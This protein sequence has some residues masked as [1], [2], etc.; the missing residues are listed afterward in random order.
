MWDAEI[1]I[2][3]RDCIYW[4]NKYGVKP[5]QHR[6]DHEIV[7]VHYPSFA[8]CYDNELGRFC[9]CSDFEPNPSRKYLYE[10]WEGFDAYIEGYKT[11]WGKNGRMFYDGIT[12]LH[13][14]NLYDFDTP[15]YGVPTYDLVFG[16]PYNPETGW[17]KATKKRYCVR[18]KKSDKYPTG[19]EIITEDIDG[20][21][22]KGEWEE[23][24]KEQKDH[25]KA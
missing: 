3:C 2:G 15:E 20:V 14:G 24:W 22:I 7:K 6:I 11:T 13:T 25:M 18:H 17:L 12:W 4:T 8:T 16:H 21:N 10:H 5:C 23:K 1:R 9:P 19:S